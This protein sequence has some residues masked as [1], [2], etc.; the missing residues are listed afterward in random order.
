MNIV[1]LTNYRSKQDI[2]A[3]AS[4]FCSYREAPLIHQILAKCSTDCDTRW[5]SGIVFGCGYT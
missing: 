4:C 1:L 3:F 2:D 5:E